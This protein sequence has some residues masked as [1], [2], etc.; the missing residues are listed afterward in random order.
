[1]KTRGLFLIPVL[2]PYSSVALNIV[3]SNRLLS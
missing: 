2:Y 3:Q 1:M